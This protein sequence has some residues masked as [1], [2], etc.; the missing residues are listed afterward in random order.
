[1]VNMSEKWAVKN[2][3]LKIS[4]K[5]VQTSLDFLYT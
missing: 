4:F 3:K 1:M 2:L 5:I